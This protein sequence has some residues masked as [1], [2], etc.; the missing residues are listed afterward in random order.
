M[1][2]K[3]DDQSQVLPEASNTTGEL[4]TAVPK[5][6]PAAS[7]QKI[8]GRGR[9]GKL[10]SLAAPIKGYLT[11]V[12]NN[13]K[14]YHLQA[15]DIMLDHLGTTPDASNPV[16]DN[17]LRAAD[18]VIVKTRQ[19]LEAMENI[20]TYVDDKF[21]E[22]ALRDSPHRDA[23]Y[24]EVQAHIETINPQKLIS[25]A[26]RDINM[27]EQE[28]NA[29]GFPVTPKITEDNNITPYEYESSDLSETDNEDLEEVDNAFAALKEHMGSEHI[30]IPNPTRHDEPRATIPP[31]IVS[32]SNHNSST[33]PHRSASQ[34][35]ATAR[36]RDSDDDAWSRKPS[37]AEELEEERHQRRL[38]Q[39]KVR[40]L[41]DT[42]Q[43]YQQAAEQSQELE[44]Q[45][46]Q[47]LRE[48]RAARQRRMDALHRERQSSPIPTLYLTPRP[49]TRDAPSPQNFEPH[50][51][52]TA[53]ITGCPVQ[54]TTRLTG[55]NT[56]EIL[57]L[58][59]M[60]AF[61]PEMRSSISQLRADQQE[62]ARQNASAIN[63]LRNDRNG[64]ATDQT[65]EQ[66]QVD[67]T[68]V[69]SSH[70]PPP[71]QINP[72]ARSLFG[73]INFETNAKNLPNFDGSGNF[74]AFRNGFETVV[75]NDARLPE[76]TKNN[77]L[78]NHLIGDA[79]QCISY[80]DDP[81][82][83]YQMT[84]KM[85]ESVYGKGDTQ[86]GLLQK[87]KCLRFHQTNTEQMKLD[88]TAHRLL[89]QRLKTTG[90]SQFDARITMGIIGKL[91]PTFMG[92]AAL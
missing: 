13:A 42:V 50:A 33:R 38:A 78:Q 26:K 64:L 18:L 49:R 81:T 4:P 73:V 57:G 68:P 34:F 27:L 83:A 23:Y 67:E 62:L 17:V 88:L 54:A 5:S 60:L 16:G 44:Q 22:D 89:A 11:R 48:M 7:T 30:T 86:S 87:F 58:N 53:Q 14:F 47:E 35:S 72:D 6:Q 55:N 79:A 77:L 75:L 37:L 70:T 29:R 80:D 19:Y 24:R 12:T 84:M 65:S 74:K 69:E 63:E 92:K 28:L 91:P 21:Q 8:R 59:E 25:D 52:E 40:A 20:R 56:T 2:S 36:F 82:M 46:V 32:P 31:S 90:L 1:N 41:Q 15:G 51:S 66:D 61:M 71:P 45:Q 43:G 3:F 39:K 9:P 76:V 85:L 10:R